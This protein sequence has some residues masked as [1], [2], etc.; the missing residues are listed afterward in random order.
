MANRTI[1]KIRD[2]EKIRSK[3][4]YERHREEVKKRNLERYH[5]NKIDKKLSKV[6]RGDNI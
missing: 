5:R 6:H 4:Y 3:K 2:Q 1:K